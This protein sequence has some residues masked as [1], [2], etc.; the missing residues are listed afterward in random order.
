MSMFEDAQ[1]SVLGAF[2]QTSWTDLGISTYPSNFAPGG[3]TSEYI[4]VSV[5]LS[6]QGVNKNSVSGVLL[7]DVFTASGDGPKRP[8]QIA[9]LLD[10][11]LKGKTF[12]NVQVSANSSLGMGEI[13]KDNPNLFHTRYSVN[14][15]YFGVD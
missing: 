9:D 11:L 6:G 3:E 7:V 15:N 4:R 1:A 10:S 14:L 12:G 13:D 8:N 2:S 5:V